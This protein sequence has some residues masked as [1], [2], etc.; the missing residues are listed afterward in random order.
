MR[1][2]VRVRAYFHVY[3]HLCVRMS[4]AIPTYV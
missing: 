4:V 1:T 2:P 3:I